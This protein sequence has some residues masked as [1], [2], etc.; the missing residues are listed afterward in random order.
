MH[1]N[2][3]AGPARSQAIFTFLHDRMQTKFAESGFAANRMVTVA[4]PVEPWSEE[5]IP[6]E[7]NREFLF[8]GR[9]GRDKGADLVAESAAQ[10]GVALTLVG[11]GEL[12]ETLRSAPGNLRL[13]GWCNRAE[14]LEH[15]RR[16]RAL[17]VPSRVVEPFGLVILEAAMSGLPVIVSDRAYLAADAERLG[18]GRN[19][20]PS[21]PGSLTGLIATLAGSD[22]QVRD[23]S[24]SGFTRSNELGSTASA[25]SER[26]LGLFHELLAEAR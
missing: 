17:I 19:F 5:R 26:F 24:Q 3:L 7:Q 8:V 14:I 21:E 2:R 22:A 23:M 20:D 1:L 25:W 11:D 9:L 16:A 12:A 15:A 10:A 18:F 13:A 4:N 6:A